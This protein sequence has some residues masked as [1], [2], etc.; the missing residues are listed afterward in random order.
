MRTISMRTILRWRDNNGCMAALGERDR[1]LD[2]AQL[3]QVASAGGRSC[4]SS[5]PVQD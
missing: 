2:A 1:A 3:D 4:N 5:N